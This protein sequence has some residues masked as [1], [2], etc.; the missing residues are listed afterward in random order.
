MTDMRIQFSEEMVGAGH[1]AK[2]D[3]IN[4]LVLVE[5]NNDGTHNK[6]TKVTDPWVDVRAYG[7]VGDGSTDDTTAIQGAIDAVNAAGGGVVY[8]PKGTYKVTTFITLKSNV[9]LE[10]EGDTSVIK[11][12]FASATNRIITSSD[13]VQQTNIKIKNL[14]VDRTGAN[15]Q[16]GIHLGGITNLEIDR[17]TVYGQGS[18][19]C[20]AIAISGFDGFAVNQSVNVKVTNCYLEESNNF[21]IAFGNVKGGLIANNT[22]INCYRELIG[23]EAYGASGVV[24][25][26]TVTGNVLMA[27]ES[28]GYHQGG[29]VGPALLVGGATSL[30]TVRNCTVTGNVIHLRN[31]VAS[32]T[33]AGI[34]LTGGTSN[35]VEDCLISNNTIYTPS[36]AGIFAGALGQVTRNCTIDGNH[37]YGANTASGG[38]A[39]AIVLRN[40]TGF[41]VQN[42]RVRGSTHAYAL[43]EETGA[44]TNHW[45]DNDVDAGTSGTVTLIGAASTCRLA[46]SVLALGGVMLQDTLAIAS[47][48]T[49]TFT[50]RGANQRGIFLISSNFGGNYAIVVMNSTGAPTVIS[51]STDFA[52]GATNPDT[53]GA[54]NLWPASSTTLSI[55]N[56]L[57]S[58]RTFV[59]TSFMTV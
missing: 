21:G 19:T 3:T 49:G 9:T 40:A 51:K 41:T 33:Y 47:E 28:A 11:G 10:G 39:S 7:A 45:L 53:P 29:S 52:T 13:S 15:A 42:N 54:A 58:E 34:N 2:V 59:V 8:L 27:D 35:P 1:P 17:V 26:V 44:N 50:V 4:R 55:K 48:A 36:G 5:H 46:T 43:L 20:G 23:L 56:R 38:T 18:T 6:L 31:S 14:K 30:G 57:G 37:I 22:F 16:H 24:E 25:D 32:S 12:V